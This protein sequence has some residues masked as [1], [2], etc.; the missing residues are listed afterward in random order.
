MKL[1]TPEQIEGHTRASRRGALEGTLVAGSI[2]TLGS[3][4]SHRR[5][6]YYRTLPPSLKVLGILVITA[7]ALSIQAERRGLEYD[8]SQWQGDGVRLLDARED[9]ANWA[10]RH[11]YSI[12]IG[13]WALSLALAGGIISRNKYQTTAQ[14]VVQARMWAQGLTI[15]IILTAAGLKHNH[16]K[17]EEASRP[18][19]DHSWMEVLE[20]QEKDRQEDQRLKARLA[21]ARRQGAPDVPL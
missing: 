19:A 3:I 16:N 7:P 5:W 1:L 15:G 4:Y 10:S 11:E 6:A 17:G 2:A 9:V 8:K 12:I 18:S 13:G 21:A 14:K 20:Q